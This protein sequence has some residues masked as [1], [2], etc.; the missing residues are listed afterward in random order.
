VSGLQSW[1]PHCLK[2]IEVP[3]PVEPLYSWETVTMLVP[4][5]RNSIETALSK[6]R[7]VLDAPPYYTGPL[8]HRRRVFTASDIV[9]LRE[10][11]VVRSRRRS[12]TKP[13]AK[14]FPKYVRRTAVSDPGEPNSEHPTEQQ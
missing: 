4:A 11:F 8:R 12:P 10:H 14:R 1:C 9:K 7:V 5:P 2:P 6:K 13:P 3:L